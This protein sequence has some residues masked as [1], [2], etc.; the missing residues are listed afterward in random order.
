M[1]TYFHSVVLEKELCMGCTNC[2]QK[3][4]TEAIRVQQ[5]KAKILN[6][7]CID[8]GECIRTCPYRAKVAQ[9]DG[10]ESLGD[11]RYTIG[12]YFVYAV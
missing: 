6:E 8:C 12:S 7:K 3:C 2:I 9:T 5:G 1:D 10:W 4:P 11:Y